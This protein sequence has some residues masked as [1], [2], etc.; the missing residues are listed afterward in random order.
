MYDKQYVNSPCCAGR[1]ETNRPSSHIPIVPKSYASIGAIHPLSLLPNNDKYPFPL[2]QNPHFPS[3]PEMFIIIF[4]STTPA[5]R[6][7]I[8]GQY[9]LQLETLLQTQPGFISEVP[10]ASPHR[11]DQAVLIAKWTD[12]AGVHVWRTQHQHLM[13]QYKARHGIF[14]AY[15]LRVGPEVSASDEDEE[16]DDTKQVTKHRGHFV[17]L[18]EA[19]IAEGTTTVSGDMSELVDPAKG[20]AVDVLADLVDAAVYRGDKSVLWISG[21][22]TR[23]AATRFEEA[24]RR[25]EGASVSVVRVVRDYG[26]DD[27]SEAP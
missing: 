8:Q 26:K 23:A 5:S 1:Y 20:A 24:I 27:R 2:P 10:F 25:V 16:G 18:H 13:I 21:W 11:E 17:V 4:E 3:P 15:R 6:T 14:D 12:E 9:Y 7:A 19:P 22:A